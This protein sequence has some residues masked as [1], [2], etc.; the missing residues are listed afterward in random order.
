MTRLLPSRSGEGVVVFAESQTKGRGRH[1]RPWVSPRGKGLWFSVLLRPQ[2]P[3]PRLTVAASVALARVVRA[4]NIEA[5]IKWPNDV[6]VNGRKVSGI[7]TETRD[8]AAILGIG[9]N[10]WGTVGGFPC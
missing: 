10:V 5:R 3:L 8:G 2:F 1:G 9:I 4:A 7:L 6:T